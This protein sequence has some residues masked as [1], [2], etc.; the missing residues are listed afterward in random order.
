MPPTRSPYSGPYRKLILAFDIGTTYSGISY[1]VLDPGVVPEIRGVNRFPATD[2]VGGNSKIPTIMY[3]DKNGAVC[4]AGAEA[5]VEGIDEIAEDEGWVKVEWFKLHLKPKKMSSGEMIPPLPTNLNKTIIEIFAD[6]M[7]YLYQCTGDYIKETH[8]NGGSLW[9]SVENRIHFVLSHPNGWE[10]P[11]QNQMRRAAVL[12]GLVPDMTAAQDRI[13][14]VTEGEAS[15]HFCIQNGLSTE[16]LNERSGILIVDA[17]GGTVDISSYALRSGSTTDFEEIAAPQCH[18]HGSV[19]VTRRAEAFFK[20]HL[21]NSQFIFDVPIITEMFDKTTKLSFKN[22][23]DPQYI[24]FGTAKDRDLS[25]GIRAG[26]LKLPGSDVASFFKPSFE[27]IVSAIKEQKSLAKIPIKSVF[28][29]GGF[30]ASSWLYSQLNKVIEPLDMS[31]S[32]PDSHLSKA[33]ADGAVSFYIDHFVSVRVAK[34]FYGTFCVAPYLP[35][36]PDHVSRSASTFINKTNG[37]RCINGMFD[38]ILPKNTAVSEAKEFRENYQQV[39]S[40]RQELLKITSSVICYRG[41]LTNP[42]WQD[43]DSG[44]YSTCC[45]IEAQIPDQIITTINKSA[46]PKNTYYSVAFD[47]VLLFGHTEM[48]AQ[49]CWRENGREKRGPASV[50]YE[51]S[52]ELL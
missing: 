45:I 15:L 37:K 5:V 27:C 19:F 52:P 51:Q 31:L 16:A 2:H 44:G 14:F 48:K 32:R 30:A 6:F 42:R 40:S 11:Q 39:S 8:G 26:Q 17:G 20:D 28:L 25:L 7:K 21:K 22:D 43:E 9:S 12:A 24:R 33:V 1:S 34:F 35:F 50:I 13:S 18:F 4:A 46:S 47:I 10:G 29:V 49:L 41:A 38:V 36:K 23:Q 3:Y